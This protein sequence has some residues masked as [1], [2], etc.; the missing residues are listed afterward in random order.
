M[1]KQYEDLIDNDLYDAIENQ[2]FSISD[3]TKQD[4]NIL[5]EIAQSSPLGEDW[6]E[7]IWVNPDDSLADVAKAFK[8]FASNFDV[9]DAASDY[10]ANR[11]QNGIPNSISDLLED[12]RWKKEVLTELGDK[13][14][15]EFGNMDKP[16]MEYEPEAEKIDM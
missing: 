11:G 2:D 6:H 8:D 15:E 4:D 5:I 14:Q 3:V 7:T 1:S 13:L 16:F 10:I 12:A 9:D